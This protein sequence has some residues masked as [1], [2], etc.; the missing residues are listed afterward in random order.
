MIRIAHYKG[1]GNLFNKIIRAFQRLRS[2]NEYAKYSHTEIVIG[3]RWYSAS[4]RENKVRVRQI[5]GRSGKWDFTD[6]PMSKK[7]MDIL[8]IF[9]KSQVGKGYDRLGIALSQILPLQIDD[10]KKWF[11]SELVAEALMIMGVLDRRKHASWYSPARLKRALENMENNIIK[12][13]R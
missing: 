9:L 7:N 10:P 2:P 3:E 4:N 5:S 6:I 12:D 11:C 1:K 13:I 8:E